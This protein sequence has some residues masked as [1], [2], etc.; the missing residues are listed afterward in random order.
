MT[1]IFCCDPDCEECREKYAGQTGHVYNSG[2]TPTTMVEVIFALGKAAGYD[3][4]EI[5]QSLWT[6]DNGRYKVGEVVYYF[7]QHSAYHGKPFRILASNIQDERNTEYLLKDLPLI[8]WE[9]EIS[10]RGVDFSYLESCGWKL[11]SMR[12]GRTYFK[13]GWF[14]HVDEKTNRTCLW[15]SEVFYEVKQY[16]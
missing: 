14:Y 12:D 15:Y 7:G 3:W 8:V 10:F 4:W 1:H 6:D 16:G 5:W 13:N 2:E 9:E 11:W